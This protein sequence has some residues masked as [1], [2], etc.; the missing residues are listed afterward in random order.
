MAKFV[1]MQARTQLSADKTNKIIFALFA[2]AI[3]IALFHALLGDWYLSQLK[4]VRGDPILFVELCCATFSLI[5]IFAA[6][7][8]AAPLMFAAEKLAEQKPP[9]IPQI[10]SVSFP[11]LIVPAAVARPNSSF[12]PPR[13]S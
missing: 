9:K 7:G 1:Q 10:F 4:I 11:A 2:A 5:A 6:F 3:G 13:F 12:R 8:F